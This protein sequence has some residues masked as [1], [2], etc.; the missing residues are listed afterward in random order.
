MTVKIPAQIARE[1]AFSFFP[2][3]RE[4]TLTDQNRLAAEPGRDK[5]RN[6]HSQRSHVGIGAIV[7]LGIN[8]EQAL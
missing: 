5:T 8:D 3:Q 4:E 6:V 7:C 2:E 1:V